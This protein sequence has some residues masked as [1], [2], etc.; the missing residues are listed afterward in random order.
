MTTSLDFA[1]VL[2]SAR[3]SAVHLEMRDSYLRD[4]LDD[5]QF[6]DWRDNGVTESDDKDSA[7]WR[8]LVRQTV[9]RGVVMRRARI[10]SEPV[11]DYIRFEHAIT[12]GHNIAA[13]ELVRWLPRQDSIGIAVPT[14]DFWLLDDH[15]VILN[16]FTGDGSWA[17][18]GGMDV[19]TDPALAKLCGEA[20]EA[21]WARGVDHPSF[22]LV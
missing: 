21:V 20:F 18:A 6:I 7:D 8:A 5:P 17:P 10:V 2:A 15:T 3:H 19:R 16:H 14:C 1:T 11:T 13:G 22:A 12:A 4:G 9:A